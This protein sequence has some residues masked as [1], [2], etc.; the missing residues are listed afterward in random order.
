MTD[1][2]QTFSGGSD[3]T[4]HREGYLEPFPYKLHGY[5]EV[6]RNVTED[7]FKWNEDLKVGQPKRRST[8]SMDRV[9]ERVLGPSILCTVDG[10][11]YVVSNVSA[12]SWCLKSQ[13]Y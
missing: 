5:P 7:P 3:G 4:V 9:E 8:N 13:A 2:V 1:E 11:Q 12:R 10:E 6:S